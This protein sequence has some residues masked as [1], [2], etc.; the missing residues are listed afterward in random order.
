MVTN[1]L[2]ANYI[3]ALDITAKKITI[4]DNSTPT[5]NILFNADGLSTT[6]SVQIAGFEVDSNSISNDNIGMAGSVLV[7]SGSTATADI[8]GSG[9]KDGWVFAAGDNFG[10]R[11]QG[12]DANDNPVSIHST[13]PAAIDSKTK[14]ELYVDSGKIGGFTISDNSLHS[15]SYPLPGFS[16][17]G[18]IISNG[19]TSSNNIGG[20]SG[21]NIWT[22]A[23]GQSF[24]VTKDGKMYANA[25]KIGEFTIEENKLTST[26]IELNNDSIYLQ[27]QKAAISLGDSLLL[28]SD[29]TAPT[30]TTATLGNSFVDC[31]SGSLVV[32]SAAN[33]NGF[34]LD[35][36]AVNSP[37][38]RLMAE[39][40][41]A[42]TTTTST[43]IKRGE[44]RVYT[45]NSNYESITAD[46]E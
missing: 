44:I 33:T 21:S 13:S 6:P 32:T 5:P 24:G 30:S 3:N 7:C 16:G 17:D 39:I 42:S 46:Y 23:S 43:G 11:L 4:Y 2:T 35:S 8:G 18:I 27:S 10:V 1:K 20:S 22:I 34:L 41:P 14:S 29:N 40:S 19:V 12:Y 9:E 36:S 45:S 37:I 25:G 15:I 26:K 31:I 38:L 28:Y